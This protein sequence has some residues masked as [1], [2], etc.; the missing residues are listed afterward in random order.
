MQ[1]L[2]GWKL[3]NTL[4]TIFAVTIGLPLIQSI[5]FF[6]QLKIADLADPSLPSNLETKMY[7]FLITSAIISTVLTYLAWRFSKSLIAKFHNLATSVETEARELQSFST[8]FTG[9]SSQLSSAGQQQASSLQQTAAAIEQISAMVIKNT[10]SAKSSQS[11]VLNFKLLTEKGKIT[12][13][14]MLSAV[15][16]ITQSNREINDA[17]V[18]SNKKIS[19]IVSVIAEIGL[20]TK[21]INDIVFQTKLLSFNASVEAARAGEHGKGFAVVAEEI[22]NLAT[23]SGAAAKE[24]SNLLGSSTQHVETIVRETTEKVDRL[25][26]VSFDKMKRGSQTASDCSQALGEI[27]TNVS[28]LNEIVS[29]I[30][31][32]SQEQS[33][34][35]TQVTQSIYQL[36]SATQ[37]N[38]VIAEQSAQTANDLQKQGHAL[39]HAVQLLLNSLHGGE[40][41]TKPV[42]INT[43]QNN[44][45][46]EKNIPT[47]A[48]TEPLKIKEPTSVRKIN[49]DKTPSANDPRFKE[50]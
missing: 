23:M 11:V 36:D 46:G 30:A 37:Q 33:H 26:K 9:T 48:T 34:G 32:A 12:A 29:E 7:S 49:F 31:V 42:A 40:L 22:G 5:Y 25:M 4:L 2:I 21:I 19:Q 1:W 15:D 41:P 16:E 14:N 50:A 35:I 28:I 39:A 45:R 8:K 20:K 13:E 6:Y 47:P 27:M 10:D 44:D 38:N 43:L 24:I 17:I 3:K 18:E